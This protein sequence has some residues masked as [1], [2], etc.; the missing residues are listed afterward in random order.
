MRARIVGLAIGS[1]CPKRT[2]AAFAI[3]VFLSFSPL[4]GL[5]IV[6]AM[7]LALALPLS[8][9]ALLVGLCANL[10]WFMVP[11]Y[12]LTTAAG[13]F[14]LGVPLSADLGGQFGRILELPIYQAAFWQRVAEFAGPFVW[15][16]VL[17]STLGALL[18]SVVA[19]VTVTR[20]LAP[21]YGRAQLA[22]GD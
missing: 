5:Q 7:G 21:L 11:W 12:T 16:F 9:S 1:G 17:G 10:P 2:A 19:Y 15:S 20:M 4:L 13:A 8:R 6:I 14:A 18:V 3:G 22:T